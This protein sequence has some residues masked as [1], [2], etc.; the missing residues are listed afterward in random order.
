MY[1]N[2]FSVRVPEGHEKMSGY[3][4]MEHGK[5]YTLVLRNDCDIRCD[6]GISIDG[7]AVGTFRLGAHGNIRLERKPDDEGCFTF[8]Q[9][10]SDEA[11]RAELGKVSASDL[12]LIRVVFTPEQQYHYVPYIPWIESWGGNTCDITPNTTTIYDT[13]AVTGDLSYASVTIDCA[14]GTGLSGHSDQSFISV[15]DMCLDYSRQTTIHL[16]LVANRDD[17]PRPLHPVTRTSPIPPPV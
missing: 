1:L 15:D 3:V 16:R 6:A 12:G 5:K 13:S 7:K 10:G 11:E 17:G 4:E 2:Q 14:G 9:L 8:Y